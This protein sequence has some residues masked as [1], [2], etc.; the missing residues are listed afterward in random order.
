M[1]GIEDRVLMDILSRAVGPERAQVAFD[2]LSLPP[3]VSIRYNPFKFRSDQ[4]GLRGSTASLRSAPPLASQSEAPVPPLTVPR[5]AWVALPKPFWSDEPG[6]RVPWCEYGMMLPER[7]R[8]VMDPL[9]HAGCYYVQDSSAMVVGHILR[10]H[11]DRFEGIGRPIRVLD[12]CAAPGGKTTD[13]STS[14]R[15]RF[16]DAFQLVA[17]E[18]MRN[19]ASVL[20][21]NVAIWGDPNVVVTSCDPKVF[22]RLEGYFDIIVTDVPCSGEGMFR[23]DPKAV[24]DWSPEAVDLCAARQKR[25]LAD[26]WPALCQGGLL[27]YSTCTFEEAENDGNVEWT[28]SE[29]GAEVIDYEYSSL[30]GVISTRTGGLLLPGFVKGEGQFVSVLEKTSS[31]GKTKLGIE[32]LKPLRNGLEKGTSKG[33]DFIPSADWA[34][35]IYPPLEEY[36]AVELDKETALKFLHRDGIFIE[37]QPAGYLIVCFEGHPL[38]FVKNIGKRWNNL[39]PQNRRIRIDL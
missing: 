10:E 17:N 24:E 33:R 30:P 26:A 1:E 28:A 13:I 9:F 37:G 7:P 8:F 36:P 25:I 39:H 3:S 31:A 19:R 5:V 6:N 4:K 20:A 21:D 23:K 32:A 16:G 15:E 29:L 35:S 11:L 12:L 27:I 34:L 22:S 14:L 38:G 18:V 2:A